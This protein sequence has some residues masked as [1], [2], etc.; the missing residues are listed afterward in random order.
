MKKILFG[1]AT[2]ALFLSA[3]NKSGTT[4]ATAIDSTAIKNKAVAMNANLAFAKKDMTAAFKDYSADF[5]EYGNGAGKPIKNIDTIKAHTQQFI[6]AFPDFKADS[7]N[8]VAEG[9]SVLITGI[10]SGTFKKAFMGIK[11]TQKSFKV[12]D[13][14]IFTF[15]KEGKINSHTSIQSDYTFFGQLGIPIPAKK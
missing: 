6:D 8:A 9:D 7:L 11:P 15:N 5:V 1:A 4:T 12:K 13:V 14:D 3:C 2:A 10:W